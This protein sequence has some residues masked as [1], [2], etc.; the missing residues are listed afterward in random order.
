MTAFFPHETTTAFGPARGPI[1]PVAAASPP[2]SL[3][4]GSS[5]P[6]SAAAVVHVAGELDAETTPRLHELLAPRLSSDAETVIIDLSGLRFLGVT[7]LRLLAHAHRSATSRSTALRL[8]DGP[9]CVDRALH[10]A[11]W[12]GTVPTYPSVA[13]ALAATTRFRATG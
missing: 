7:G 4:L 9:V 5:R 6:T 12:T 2:A 1:D 11:G 3:E 8:V 10:A 13:A